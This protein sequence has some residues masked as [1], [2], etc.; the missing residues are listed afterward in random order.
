TRLSLF[1]EKGKVKVR[2]A[3]ALRPL[4]P[5]TSLLEPT[6]PQ[7]R[8]VSTMAQSLPTPPGNPRQGNVWTT[9]SPSLSLKLQ[10]RFC[11]KFHLHLCPQGQGAAGGGR[12]FGA[13][14]HVQGRTQVSECPQSNVQIAVMS[15]VKPLPGTQ[16]LWQTIGAAVDNAAEHTQVHSQ[17]LVW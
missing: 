8:K 14:F 5:Q 15:R 17:T 1:V 3:A 13:C 10:S 11:L 16:C 9:A 6:R 4:W 12:W 2:A 7:Q